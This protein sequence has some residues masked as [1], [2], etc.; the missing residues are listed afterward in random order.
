MRRPSLRRR[1]VAV[2]ITLVAVVAAA[3]GLVSTLALRGSL[4]A[5]LDERL[6]A[7]SERAALAQEGFPGGFPP[8]GEL[9]GDD[10]PEDLPD[11]LPDGDRP[12]A[13]D[14]RGQGAGT[15]TL[16]LQDGE[17]RSEYIDDAG[18]LQELTADQEAV[19]AAVAADGVARTVHLDELGEYRVVAVT[20][21][22]GDL[23]VTG[24]SS[25][26]A[27]ATVREYLMVEG[28]VA[29]LAIGA[30]A[31]TGT[32]LVRRELRP[33][34]RVA[35]TAT[36]VAELPLHEGEVL[37][38]ERVPAKDTDPATEVGQVGAALNQLL[39]HVEGALA[40]RQSS[41]TQVR[42][43]VAD[44][45]HEL[46]TPL[47]SI[48][49]YAELVRRL[50]DDLPDDA[51][52]AMERVE[53]EARRMTTLVE[54]MLLLARLDAGRPL[55]SAEVDL[56][57]LAV[58]AV[59]DAHVAGPGHHWRLELPGETAPASGDRPALEDADLEDLE[60]L[61]SLDLTDLDLDLEAGETTDAPALVVGDEDRLRQVLVNLLSN[62]R[63]HTPPGTT[64]VTSVRLDGDDVLLE[65]RDDG[66]G[67]APGL[68][69][70]L[71]DRFV[72]GDAAR[73]PGTGSS[74]LGLAIAHAV[75]AAH[76]G[77]LT[78]DSTP[79]ATTF[80]V[81]LPAAGEARGE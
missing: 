60:D 27:T 64:V 23:L 45:S 62:A 57:A 14:A 2:V 35:A 10:V 42:Q 40:A 16:T 41:E 29:A 28:L 51:V 44:A 74:G 49:G 54:D 53:S 7:T 63:V 3:M 47:A 21:E 17:V 73:T 46:R 12:P 50:P 15:V 59:M 68:R 52:R 25:A 38:A 31:V 66:P 18:D 58:D 32:V 33:L 37:L 13:F 72:R 76:R 11:P 78:V 61:E 19:L 77:T 48:R 65:V 30:A 69:E 43:F 39:G 81:R 79:G 67:I 71:F 80:A 20:T 34:E 26:D 70:H 24:L 5:Q 8:G 6:A 4:V 36:R 56:C 1:L 9:S 22:S 55:A 75:V